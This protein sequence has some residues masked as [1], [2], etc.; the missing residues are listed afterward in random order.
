MLIQSGRQS[1]SACER[2]RG[3]VRNS[4]LRFEFRMGLVIEM[5]GNEAGVFGRGQKLC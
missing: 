2:R 5:P 4:T 1:G 3:K